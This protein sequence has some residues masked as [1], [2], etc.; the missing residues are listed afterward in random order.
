MVSCG[1]H[2]IIFQP[3]NVCFPADGKVAFLGW[4]TYLSQ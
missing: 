4:N 1:T 3:W 2:T